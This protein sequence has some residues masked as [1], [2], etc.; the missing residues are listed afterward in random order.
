[1]KGLR[2][3]TYLQHCLYKPLFF[4]G[5]NY[6]SVN[7][8]S[9][10]DR[11]TYPSEELLDSHSCGRPP[12]SNPWNRGLFFFVSVKPQHIVGGAEI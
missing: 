5:F 4:K 8:D 7:L 10:R 1:M 3:A 9:Q 2:L 12:D 11:E 6:Q